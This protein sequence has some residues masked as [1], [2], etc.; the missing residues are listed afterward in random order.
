MSTLVCFG[1]C[2]LIIALNATIICLIQ[3]VTKNFIEEDNVLN[4]VIYCFLTSLIETFMLIEI[5]K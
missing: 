1:L 2:I 4:Y 3:I 5:L